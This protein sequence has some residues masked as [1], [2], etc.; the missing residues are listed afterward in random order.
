MGNK[1]IDEN[2]I[3]KLRGQENGKYLT[4]TSYAQVD[5]FVNTVMNIQTTYKTRSV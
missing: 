5:G 3:L 1:C 2:V 4:D